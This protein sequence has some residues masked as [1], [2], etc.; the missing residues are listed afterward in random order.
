MYIVA[1][2]L[3][4]K[5]IPQCFCNTKLCKP[6]PVNLFWLIAKIASWIP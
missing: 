1:D 5:Q 4:S 6:L 2:L 3:G